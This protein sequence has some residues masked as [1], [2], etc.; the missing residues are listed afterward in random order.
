MSIY[1]DMLTRFIQVA[2]ERGHIYMDAFPGR[3]LDNLTTKLRRRS[4][5][6]K[7]G[8]NAHTTTPSV[9]WLPVP[10]PPQFVYLLFFAF[11]YA[12]VLSII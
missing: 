3:T 10:K 9:A 1:V 8:E 12:L 2:Q 6:K 7:L 5:S 4:V 11:V